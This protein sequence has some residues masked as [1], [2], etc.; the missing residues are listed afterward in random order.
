M[1]IMKHKATKHGIMKHGSNETWRRSEAYN[2]K[3]YN[4]KA[5]KRNEVGE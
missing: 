1:G 3:T 5:R 4:N 2:I